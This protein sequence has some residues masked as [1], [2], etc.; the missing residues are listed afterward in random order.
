MK[1]DERSDSGRE[2]EEFIRLMRCGHGRCAVMLQG[3]PERYREAVRYGCLND[4]SY[5]MQCEGSRGGYMYRLACRFGENGD[6]LA[7]AAEKLLREEPLGNWNLFCHLCDFV[8]GYAFDGNAFAAGV[9][10]ETYVRLFR[11]IMTT[12]AGAA[13]SAL[14]DS[15]EYT[16]ILLMQLK[17]SE[18]LTEL[19]GD[20]GAY[21]IRRRRAE[22]SSLQGDF[23][24]FFTCAAEKYEEDFLQKL[25]QTSPQLRRFVR[26][27]GSGRKYH[28][29]MSEAPNAGEICERV[30]AGG[31]GP[32]ERVLF[33]RQAGTEEKRK[34]AEA[35]LAEKDE[36]RAA[37][38]LRMFTAEYN[39]F[40]LDPAPLIQYAVCRRGER[41]DAAL[42][43]LSYIRADS[44]HK[45][46]VRLLDGADSMENGTD[47]GLA[48]SAAEVSG[49]S[50]A[51]VAADALCMLLRNYRESDFNLLL[52]ALGRL[53]ID[54]EDGNGW[55]G[56]V[57]RIL[58][59]AEQSGLPDEALRFVYE[60]SICSCCRKDAV[61][62]MQKRGILTGAL[63]EECLFDCNEEIRE[64]AGR[65]A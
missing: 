18:R 3:A 23:L 30:S 48:S 8:A 44:V 33:G 37:A 12:R 63:A 29:R 40:P 52:R 42:D 22:D 62:L 41:R 45:L 24:W 64:L 34:L 55:H 59:E 53:E 58:D 27:M 31:A 20:M 11:G 1:P 57:C 21:F 56:V 26:V 5:D 60:K 6:F 7:E 2:E 36:E 28:A 25:D 16:A 49:I 43:A 47:G 65:P 10:E 15:Y 61:E 9:L 38:L 4:L 19:A 51:S 35:A 50:D 39:V 13:H 17:G 46:A 32:R 14:V 54:P